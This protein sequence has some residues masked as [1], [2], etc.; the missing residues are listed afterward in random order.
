[1]AEQ[2]YLPQREAGVRAVVLAAARGKELGDLTREKPKAMVDV[3]SSSLLELILE[4]YHAVGIKDITVVRGYHKETINLPGV[5]YA[6]N[7][8]F[9]KTGELYSLQKA[10]SL[11]DCEG[12][13]TI[14]SYGDVLFRKYILEMLADSPEDLVVAVDTAW[15]ESLN[16]NRQADYV[17]CSN[18]Y[19][20]KSLGEPVWLER[21]LHDPRGVHVHGEWMGFLKISA[22][23]CGEVSEKLQTILE[24]PGGSTAPMGHLINALIASGH[25]VRVLYTTGNWID[26][27]IPADLTVAGGFR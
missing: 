1:L 22:G 18:P 17:T 2:R 26:I 16:K 3:G 14:V 20:R 10:L 13:D 21:V 25:K 24:G 5:R 11:L 15:Q 4:G 7:D 27:D 19:S 12:K 23:M 6:D 9:A 8:Q